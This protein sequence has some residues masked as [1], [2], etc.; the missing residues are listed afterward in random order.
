MK[1]NEQNELTS[2]RETD[3]DREQTDSSGE[4]IRGWGRGT[5][6]KEKQLMDMDNSVGIAGGAGLIQGG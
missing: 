1:S 5:E 6:Q 2:K 4:G 3:I